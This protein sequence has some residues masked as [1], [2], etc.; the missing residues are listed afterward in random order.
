MR[1]GLGTVVCN[2]PGIS[3]A[4]PLF[5]WT[6]FFD[7]LCVPATTANTLT[8]ISPTDPNSPMNPNVCYGG[9]ALLNQSACL[10]AQAAAAAQVAAGNPTGAAAY[11][12]SQASLPWACY[13]GITDPL[14]NIQTSGV[15][16]MG[17]A[18][19]ALFM[20]VKR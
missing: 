10:S 16:I 7:P 20:A 3:P 2:P 17:L 11:D 1:M 13:L 19:F 14:G 6:A 18:A 12:C 5:S 15:L 8:S 4:D 9:G